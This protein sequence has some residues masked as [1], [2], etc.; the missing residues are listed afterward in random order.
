MRE[1]KAPSKIDDA[2]HTVKDW[3]RNI[4]IKFGNGEPKNETIS[5]Y[6]GSLIFAIEEILEQVLSK[7]RKELLDKTEE[8]VKDLSYAGVM[9]SNDKRRGYDVARAEFLII[10]NQLRK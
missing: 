7:Q 9:D 3:K 2:G 4:Q 1:I 10:L 8:K 5:G 6:L